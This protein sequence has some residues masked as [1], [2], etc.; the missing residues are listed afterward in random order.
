MLVRT[1][2]A[3]IGIPLLRDG[4]LMI[5]VGAVTTTPLGAA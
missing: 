2:S 1:G 3:D 4:R 5:A